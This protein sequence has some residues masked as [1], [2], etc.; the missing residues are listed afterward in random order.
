M[1][2]FYLLKLFY[3][4]IFFFLFSFFNDSLIVQN[5]GTFRILSSMVFETVKIKGKRNKN[6]CFP[7]KIFNFQFFKTFRDL[8]TNFSIDKANV[9]E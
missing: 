6:A 9:S 2:D 5:Q 3:F 7:D 8:K 1:L 4:Y